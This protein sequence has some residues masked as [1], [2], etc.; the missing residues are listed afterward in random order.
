MG[1]DVQ[2]PPPQPDVP[3]ASA[4]AEPVPPGPAPEAAAGVSEQKRGYPGE[5]EQPSPQAQETQKPT[6]DQLMGAIESATDSMSLMSAIAQ[7]EKMLSIDKVRL[8]AMAHEKA[9]GFGDREATLMY[10]N[11]AA[12]E[13]NAQAATRMHE[14]VNGMNQVSVQMKAAGDQ[15]WASADLMSRTS[16]RL[17][18]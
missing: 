11:R 12:A 13:M 14:A 2:L 16:H 10:G 8:M 7:A 18:Q 15:M 1:E 5:V 9:A 17:Q 3:P 4:E 6:Y